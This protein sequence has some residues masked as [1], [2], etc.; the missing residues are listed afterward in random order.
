MFCD[1]LLDI[2]LLPAASKQ[3]RVL[4]CRPLLLSLSCT[5]LLVNEKAI[6]D[7]RAEV[8]SPANCFF[9]ASCKLDRHGKSF[10]FGC[11][12]SPALNEVVRD[13]PVLSFFPLP[14]S[15]RMYH[16]S[17]QVFL[18]ARYSSFSFLPY[19]QSALSGVAHQTHSCCRLPVGWTEI[20]RNLC[21]SPLLSLDVFSCSPALKGL[22]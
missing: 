15:A 18:F 14:A 7:E 1:S 11:Y 2:V 20:R 19:C 8:S 16:D 22:V 6:L 21:L 3:V 4:L 17:S 10:A 5:L 12:L 9:Q 13:F